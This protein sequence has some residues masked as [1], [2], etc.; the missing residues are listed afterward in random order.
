VKKSA[1]GSGVGEGV[2]EGVDMG[3]GG[4]V[5]A[6]V[7]EGDGE[8]VVVRAVAVWEGEG[9]GGAVRS[10]R[11]YTE[12][13]DNAAPTASNMTILTVAFLIMDV[14]PFPCLYL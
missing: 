7:G 8:S 3:E 10:G 13:A 2:G 6:G 12:H 5:E 4:G 9:K 1:H 11:A 14:Y